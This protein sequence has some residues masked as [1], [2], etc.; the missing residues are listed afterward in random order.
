MRA[1]SAALVRSLAAS[2]GADEVVLLVALGL[3][4]AGLWSRIGALSLMLPGLVLL[5]IALPQRARFV[6]R[7]PETKA[8]RRA[9]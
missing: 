1:R 7:D 8:E 4:T 6:T 2:I 3:L 5:W 9:R